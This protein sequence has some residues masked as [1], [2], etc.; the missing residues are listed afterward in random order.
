[1]SQQTQSQRQ[2]HPQNGQRKKREAPASI[3]ALQHRDYVESLFAS[4]YLP[5]WV[6]RMWGP[7]LS[8]DHV[9]ANLEDWEVDSDSFLVDISSEMINAS[10][11][12]R[13]SVWGIV[14]D[15]E[16]EKTRKGTVTLPVRLWEYV[17][18]EDRLLHSAEK[19]T[20]NHQ[21]ERLVKGRN[22]RSTGAMQQKAISDVVQH[23]IHENVSENKDSGGMFSWIKNRIT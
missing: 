3:Q 14:V 13:D 19:V 7:E 6:Y 10:M 12:P 5:E 1:M 9:L 4:D 20:T 18:D 21:M 22:S 16:E 17:F 11:I 8:R 23:T 15:E 2:Q